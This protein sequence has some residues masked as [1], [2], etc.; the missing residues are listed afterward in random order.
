[1]TSLPIFPGLTA[2]SSGPFAAAPD[3]EVILSEGELP[4]ESGQSQP[5][6]FATFLAAMLPALPAPTDTPQTIAP[7]A[8]ETTSSTQAAEDGD[9]P[10]VT[11]INLATETLKEWNATPLAPPAFGINETKLLSELKTLISQATAKA[12]SNEIDLPTNITGIDHDVTA[13]QSEQQSLDYAPENAETAEI[14]AVPVQIPK[15]TVSKT[16]DETIKT[17]SNDLIASIS[18]SLRDSSEA[19]PTNKPVISSVTGNPVQEGSTKKE[20][21]EDSQDVPVLEK[22][23]PIHSPTP[24]E[25]ILMKSVRE[26]VPPQK[27]VSN[28]PLQ[29]TSSSIT[30]KSDLSGKILISSVVNANLSELSPTA[31]YDADLNNEAFAI[32]E[33]L[34]VNQTLSEVT[35][36]ET[37]T[38]SPES[39]D[40]IATTNQSFVIKPEH[41]ETPVFI[42]SNA[43]SM[44]EDGLL[45]VS[46]VPELNEIV[47]LSSPPSPKPE[48]I[49]IA[50]DANELTSETLLQQII[51]QATEA[52]PK[53]VDLTFDKLEVS[54]KTESNFVHEQTTEN[55]PLTDQ[56]ELPIELPVDLPITIQPTD[57]QKTFQPR[58]G[59][60]LTPAMAI[61]NFGR[62]ESALKPALREVARITAELLR[63]I[64]GEATELSPNDTSLSVSP[65]QSSLTDQ[66]EMPQIQATANTQPLA[67]ET[68]AQGTEIAPVITASQID[69]QMAAES[70]TTAPEIQRTMAEKFQRLTENIGSSDSPKTANNSPNKKLSASNEA[71]REVMSSAIQSSPVSFSGN[72]ATMGEGSMQQQSNESLN[73]KEMNESLPKVSKENEFTIDDKTTTSQ[74]MNLVAAHAPQVA[75]GRTV[76]MHS[77]QAAVTQSATQIINAAEGIKPRETRTMRFELR[78]ESLG[79]VEIELTRNSEGQVR[80]HLTAER[81]ETSQFLQDGLGQLRESL[82]RAGINVDRLDV[83]TRS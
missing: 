19:I 39:S 32:R 59:E 7:A 82:E 74:P 23:S 16:D 63:Q 44:P 37:V 28:Q 69:K 81:G 49:A 60:A 31:N 13:N 50:K 35:P 62:I 76:N 54:P 46:D 27:M 4:I 20:A 26:A 47:S 51:A 36:T 8:T 1:M 6:T 25:S 41:S 11:Q 57:I 83:S 10:S 34:P 80:A 40:P 72:E 56:I 67:A 55:I 68:K 21:K 64:D 75:L 9:S 33:A 73:H 58:Q 79:R 2:S 5:D 42:A 38:K 48:K 12:T 29:Q 14:M 66:T 65:F 17:Q 30:H 3:E 15:H 18:D 71:A 70:A 78:P 24:A 53:R 52:K 22:I 61:E 45:S 77:Q 43:I